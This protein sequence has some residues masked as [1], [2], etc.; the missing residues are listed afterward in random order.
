MSRKQF[1]AGPSEQC[2]KHVFGQCPAGGFSW[3]L[4]L[5]TTCC[6]LCQALLGTICGA[7]LGDH[8]FNAVKWHRAVGDDCVRFRL[9]KRNA[10]VLCS[11]MMEPMNSVLK[12]LPSCFVLNFYGSRKITTILFFFFD[13]P[14]FSDVKN[15]VYLVSRPSRPPAMSPA[16]NMDFW[17]NEHPRWNTNSFQ[18]WC[19]KMW[20][21]ISG[22]ITSPPVYPWMAPESC[23]VASFPDEF[24][25]ISVSEITS[26]S[27]LESEIE[28]WTLEFP[29][30]CSVY[31]SFSRMLVSLLT[32]FETWVHHLHPW[33]N[34]WRASTP[35]LLMNKNAGVWPFT[36]GILFILILYTFLSDFMRKI[37]WFS[38]S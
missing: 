6:C 13:T 26:S 11:P 8:T 38:V 4:S 30:N 22:S 33:L 32:N 37:F 15:T 1:S 16:H 14:W 9:P 23:L 34:H 2:C 10:F 21:M 12:V 18:L 25:P 35:K 17:L 27:T 24:D 7:R 20:P 19:M 3:L 36:L 28:L 29:T 31:L 5:E